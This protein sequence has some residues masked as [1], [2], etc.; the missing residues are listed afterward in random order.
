MFLG[1]GL[2]LSFS[3]PGTSKAL[4]QVSSSF[5]EGQLLGPGSPSH[6]TTDYGGCLHSME[7][8]LQPPPPVQRVMDPGM[9]QV[10]RLRYLEP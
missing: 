6:G 1:T 2:T 8:P 4:P 5:M 10:L 3:F 7:I 9:G